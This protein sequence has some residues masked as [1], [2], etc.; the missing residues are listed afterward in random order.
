MGHSI[1]MIKA[2]L[3]QNKIPA[4]SGGKT[5]S[6]SA[7]R[8]ILKNEKYCGDVLMQKTYV[9]DCISKKTI[10]NTGQLPMYLLKNHHEGI[11]G[12]DKFNAVQAEFAR[13]NAGRTP[14]K[15]YTTTGR[16]CFSGKYALTERLI[17]G[18]CGTLYRRCVWNKRGRKWAVWRCASRVDYGTKYCRQSPT[19]YEK[20]LQRA[21]LAVL[22]SVMGPKKALVGQIA[23]AMR[24]ELL[25]L[26]GGTMSMADMDRRLKELE[27]E[28]Q[29][30]FQKSREKP[31]GF[32]EYAQAFQKIN[33]EA[34]MLKEQRS[35]LLDQQQSDSAAHGR[36][37]HAINVLNNGEAEITEWDESIVRQLVDT[38][39]VLSEDRI[40]VR[41]Y[42]GME[43][44]QELDKERS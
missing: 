34:A 24:M 41:L 43:F 31:D 18:D 13:R 10:R 36:I 40:R 33:E 11:V 25:P 3:E 29:A 12:R 37:A 30:V 23:D 21:I 17:C 26:P 28:F 5:W 14:N 15:R 44:E 38:V 8:N 22:N 20:P 7:I 1:R 2:E 19:L 9:S 27:R 39:T 32:M 42:G 35:R 16:S 4:A 6:E